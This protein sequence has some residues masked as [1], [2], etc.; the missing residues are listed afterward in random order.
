M[1]STFCNHFFLSQ[2]FFLSKYENHTHTHTQLDNSFCEHSVD[3]G[4][5]RTLVDGGQSQGHGSATG[6][7]S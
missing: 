4:H 1:S 2:F 6:I 3:T 7:W 5:N